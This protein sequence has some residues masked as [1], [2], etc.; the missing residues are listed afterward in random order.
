MVYAIG[1]VSGCHINPAISISMLVAGKLT[2]LVYQMPGAP[3][4]PQDI[5]EYLEK[6]FG[7]FY[8]SRNAC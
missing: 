7:K 6:R 2:F 5:Q 3:N 8:V 1:G 4:C